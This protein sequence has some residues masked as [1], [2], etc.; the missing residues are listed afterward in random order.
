MNRRN[1]DRI[2]IL[3]A[4]AFGHAVAS[5]LA[6]IRAD[7]SETVVAGNVVPLP[8]TWPPSRMNVL[9]SWRPAP[10]LCELLEQEAFSRTLPFIP[11]MLDSTALRLGPVVLPGEGC[12][13]MCWAKR[14]KHH[15]E[16][17]EAHAALM[18]HYGATPEA[19][20]KGYLEPFAL[21]AAARLSELIEDVDSL[22]ASGGYIW[23][24]D[25][26]TRE[27][28]TSIALGFHNCPRC[29]LHRDATQRSYATLRQD[30]AY[31]WAQGSGEA[32]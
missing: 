32:K 26:M 23:Q 8:E 28:T 25:M 13:W 9:A 7:V 15:A 22:K 2:H 21:L 24:I 5:H 16:W 29:G 20:P 1:P 11:L 14:W 12:C 18:A 3:S 27:I 19:G 17:P 31:L 4:G 6:S 30:L 10:A